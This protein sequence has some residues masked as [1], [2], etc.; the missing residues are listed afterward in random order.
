MSFRFIAGA[1]DFI[2]QRKAREEW[3]VLAQTVSDANSV[4]VIDGQAGNIDE[5]TKA[6]T[7]FISAVQTVSLFSPEKAIWFK[8]ITFLADSVTGRAQGTLEQV[9]R[10][11]ELLGNYDETAVKVLLSASP[12]DRRK[13][14]Y[15]WFQ[16]NGES[17]FIEAGK[18]NSA[19]IDMAREEARISGAEFTGNAAQILVE[20]TGGST[21]LTLE[22]TRKLT[23]FLGPDGG[24]ITPELVG[25]LVP[26]VGESDFFEAAEAFYSLNLEWA[27]AAVHRHFFAGHDAR[28]LIS[29]LQNRNRLLIQLKA[30][31]QS[32]ALPGRV[33]KSAL[34]QA[35]ERYAG[36]FGEAPGKS[37]FCVFTQNP[38]YLG[39]LAESLNRLN[40]KHLME[41]QEAFREAFLEIISRPNE[42]EAV[43]KAMTVKCLSPLQAGRT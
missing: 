28:P 15:K 23:T 35:A 1:D 39:R 41:F 33:S 2:V 8:N 24:K 18:D 40:L 25:E 16:S 29:S 27:L 12:V 6:V 36:Y 19:V 10:L 43:L 38:W 21:R 26:S 17:T 22:E 34:E 32:R 5:V 13:R 37:S 20:L 9:E 4:E 11:Q 14:A 3:D 42:Q 30:L 31:Q 7:Q